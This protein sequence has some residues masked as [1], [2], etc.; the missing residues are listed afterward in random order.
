VGEKRQDFLGA[1][2]V[3]VPVNEFSSRSG[4]EELVA[5]EPI[6]FGIGLVEQEWNSPLPK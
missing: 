4:Q 2:G 3:Q 6:L 5:C 1:D